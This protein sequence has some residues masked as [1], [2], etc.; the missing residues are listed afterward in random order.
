M[1]NQHCSG[2]FQTW[3]TGFLGTTSNKVFFGCFTF[4]PKEWLDST[5][6]LAASWVFKPQVKGAECT[7]LTQC[8]AAA[9]AA[10][11]APGRTFL[12]GHMPLAVKAPSTAA[13]DS[14]L[15]PVL[16]AAASQDT[17]AAT[18]IGNNGAAPDEIC[19]DFLGSNHQI[20]QTL[21][22]AT[23]TNSKLQPNMAN[24]YHCGL[25]HTSSCQ[26]HCQLKPLLQE[27][28]RNG[29][30]VVP[31]FT[32]SNGTRLGHFFRR[33]VSQHFL[34]FTF[35]KI[36]FISFAILTLLYLESLLY[37]IVGHYF[38]TSPHAQ[39]HPLMPKPMPTANTGNSS[40]R[41]KCQLSNGSRRSTPWC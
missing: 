20:L 18:S 31:A 16:S 6:F 10:N 28:V 33:M 13:G 8:L 37:W 23:M 34:T 26:L 3:D 5:K 2:S 21:E 27:L 39:L 7:S 30:A 24:T 1:I 32:T 19:W 12:P 29:N 36:D 11:P 35:I 14:D 38:Y 9:L 25:R 17:S 22:G 41:L 40:N 15:G 4:P